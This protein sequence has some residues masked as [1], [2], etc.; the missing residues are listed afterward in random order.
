M[1]WSLEEVNTTHVNALANLKMLGYN[2]V[3]VEA[4]FR[5]ELNKKTSRSQDIYEIYQSR[6]QKTLLEGKRPELP[7]EFMRARLA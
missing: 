3:E 6:V 2:P 1:P 5:E 7:V 4:I